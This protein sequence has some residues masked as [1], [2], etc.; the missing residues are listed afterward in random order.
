M[1][2]PRAGN[3]VQHKQDREAYETCKKINSVARIMLLRSMD[4]DLMREFKVH[5]S[6]KNLWEDIKIKLG[7]T[8]VTRLRSLII[9]FDTYKKCLDVPMKSHLRQMP[10]MINELA[11]TGH[12]LTDEQQV[13]AVIHSLPYSWDHL[14]ITLTHNEYIR[15]FEGLR[16]HL[17][18]KE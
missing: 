14:K 1:N 6:A 2:K 18:L 7:T 9:K 4:N 16:Q 11:D 5:A 17:D 15:T 13:Q 3:R 12:V 8:S 10:N